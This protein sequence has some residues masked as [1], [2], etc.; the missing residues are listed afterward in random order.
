MPFISIICPTMRVGGLDVLFDSLR[1]QTF[2]DFELVLVD[3]LRPLRAEIVTEEARN[4]FLRVVHVEPEPNPFPRAAYCACANAGLR[5]ASGEV[6]LFV[7]DYTHLPPGAVAKHAEFHRRADRHQGLMLP[8]R[9]V[10]LEVDKHFPRY[11]ADE[12]EMYV[13]DLLHLKKF[14]WSIGRVQLDVP[15]QPHR[16]HDGT[17]AQPDADPKL[18]ASKGPVDPL[19]FHAK[20]ESV[21]LD[22]AL[23]TGG[24]CEELDGSHGWQDSEFADRLS[25]AHGVKWYVDPDP[26]TVALITNPRS[27]FP[28]AAQDRPFGTNE[29]IWL[30]RRGA[31]YQPPLPSLKEHSGRNRGP[32]EPASRGAVSGAEVATPRPAPA[33][34]TAGADLPLR[35]LRVA[36]IY[37]EFSTGLHGKFDPAGLYTRRGLT[38]SES[39]F[40]NLGRSLAERGHEVAAFCPC[41]EPYDHPSGLAILPI[42]VLPT[43]QEQPDVDA[44]IAWSEPDYLYFAPPGA[45]R[46]VDQQLNDWNYCRAP[47]WGDRVDLFVFPSENSRQHHVRDEG[48][49]VAGEEP[50]AGGKV[51]FSKWAVVP[52]SVD[53]DLFA[54]EAPARN[55]RRVVWC[56]SP[57]RGLHHLLSW[58]PAIRARVPDAELRIFYR[59]KPWL[60]HFSTVD[61]PEGRRA[62]Y[63]EE[64]LPR[65]APMGV[66]VCDSVP[67]ARMA[68]ELREAAVLAY[69]CDPVRY[70]EG[71]G[72]SVLDAAA[73]GAQPI[74]SDADALSEVHGSAAFVVEGRPG[75]RR[76]KWIK[77]ICDALLHID[78]DVEDSD[79]RAHAE[80]HSR[81]RVAEQWEELLRQRIKRS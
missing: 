29:E 49:K 73:G 71:F 43:L 33:A 31:K 20:N 40:F 47:G 61:L 46:V 79:M 72:C 17:L 74:I 26:Q 8:H 15:A 59:L 50:L 70:T 28:L 51:G 16:V 22:V 65:L 52:N 36:M 55:L 39:S 68:R 3:G 30:R 13:N 57:D 25:L 54:G 9:Y 6:A 1:A 11:G 56:S 38:G 23:E 78:H 48:L 21:R 35:P 27:V 2:T 53:L 19:W 66:T 4:R 77:T 37:G 69:P 42:S 64:M 41:D 63:I 32:A 34:C 14:I 67:N 80:K 12:V 24:F 7:V 10:H 60:E 81:Q 75:E 62:R 45:L 18:R 58:W 5:A 76:D 44:V